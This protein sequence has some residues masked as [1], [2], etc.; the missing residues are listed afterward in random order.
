MPETIKITNIQFKRGTKEKLEARL[1]ATDLGIPKDGE[2]IFETDTGKLKI[3]DGVKPYVELDYLAGGG[4]DTRFVITDPQ[5]GQV[6]VYDVDIEAWVNVPAAEIPSLHEAIQ[7]AGNYATQAGNAAI[8]AEK[9]KVEAAK[10]NEQTMKYVNE[11][12]W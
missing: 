12:F 11:K 5:D 10:I 7:M 1:V 3:G 8:A 6:L 9:S 2:P 4:E